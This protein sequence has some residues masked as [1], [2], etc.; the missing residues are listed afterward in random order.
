MGKSKVAFSNLGVLD[1]CKFNDILLLRVQKKL[2]CHI[3]FC[4]LCK[5]IC[6][7]SHFIFVIYVINAFLTHQY[8]KIKI[9]VF[10]S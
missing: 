3:I 7:D 8:I 2:L 1:F 10:C 9:K 5:Q 6:H 4:K